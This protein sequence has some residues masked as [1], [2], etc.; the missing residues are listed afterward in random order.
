MKFNEKPIG[1]GRP[2]SRR[3]KFIRLI[4]IRARTRKGNGMYAVYET[5]EY[6]RD[7]LFSPFNIFIFDLYESPND[8]RPREDNYSW[9]I[10]TYV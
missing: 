8:P 1:G 9:E 10:N 3:P 4:I 5:R 2:P 6:A 7:I